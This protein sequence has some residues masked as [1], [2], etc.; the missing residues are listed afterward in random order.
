MFL[1]SHVLFLTLISYVVQ[2]ELGK[3]LYE[4]LSSLPDVRVYGPRPSESVHRGALCSFNVEGLHPTDLATFL[5]QQ[6]C[7]N[8]ELSLPSHACFLLSSI[9]I[10]SLNKS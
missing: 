8:W 5:D 7:Y 4:K 6:V 9:D 10:Y 3:Y 2:V 1:F